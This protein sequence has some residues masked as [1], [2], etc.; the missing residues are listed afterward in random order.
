MTLTQIVRW[1]DNTADLRRNLAQGLDMIESTRVGAEKMMQ[2][3][4]G[5]KLIESAHRMTAAIGLLEKGVSSLNPQEAASKLAFLEKAMD[6]MART[7]QPIPSHM[8][9]M[10]ESLRAAIPT[11]DKLADEANRLA[12]SFGGSDLLRNANAMVM[13]V[14]KV[15]GVSKLTRSEQDDLNRTL[16]QAISKYRALGQQAPRSMLELAEATRRVEEPTTSLTT[17]MIAIG[18]AIGTFIGRIAYDAVRRL[19]SAISDIAS[20]GVQMVGLT[21]SFERL[22]RSVG[23]TGDEML[24][25]SRTATKG[26]IADLDLMAATNKGILLGLPITT[27]SMA[28][29]ARTAVVLGKAMNQSATKSLDDL[30][31]ALGRSSPMILDNLGLSVKVG[32]ANEQYAKSL[33][34]SASALTE[35]EKKLAFYNAAMAA[36]RAKVSELGDAQLTLAEMFQQGRVFFDNFTT[37]VV[38]MVARSPRLLTA[39]SETG[40]AIR[41]AF[42]GDNEQIIA[43]IAGAIEK[44]LVFVVDAV[45]KFVELPGPARL[46][47]AGIGAITIA[48]VPAAVAVSQLAGAFAALNASGAMGILGKLAPFLTGAAAIGVGGLGVGALLAKRDMDAFLAQSNERLP[49]G[50][51]PHLNAAGEAVGKLNLGLT[52]IGVSLEAAKQGFGGLT[53]SSTEAAAALALTEDEL[54]RI[55]QAVDQ[56]TGASASQELLLLSRAI[57]QI[58]TSGLVVAESQLG[59][60]VKKIHELSM[61]GGQIPPMLLEWFAANVSLERIGARVNTSVDQVTK[62]IRE[63]VGA[64]NLVLPPHIQLLNAMN[65]APDIAK[66]A[67]AGFAALGSGAGEQ[68]A[69]LRD[70]LKGMGDINAEWTMRF[71]SGLDRAKLKAEQWREH[72]LG[73]VAHLKTTLPQQWQEAVTKINEI[74]ASMVADFETGAQQIRRVLSESFASAIGSAAS[75]TN[76][77]DAARA[78]VTS[79]LGAIPVAGSVLGPLVGGLFDIGA[80]DRAMRQSH[81]DRLLG[82]LSERMNELTRATER[83]GGVV[84][85]ALRPL[86]DGLLKS[87]KLTAEMRMQLEALGGA[88][89]LEA[90]REAAQRYGRTLDQLGPKLAQLDLSSTFDQLFTDFTMLSDAGADSTELLKAMAPA[91]NDAL[92]RARRLGLK[93]PEFMRPMLESMLKMGLLT[94]EFGKQLDTLNGFEFSDSI[95]SSLSRIAEILERIEKALSNPILPELLGHTI[96]DAPPIGMAGPREPT[97]EHTTIVEVEGQVLARATTPWLP[98]EVR[99]LRLAP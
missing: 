50:G 92:D 61:A 85:S 11:V 79:F 76:G 25:V 83:F 63:Q 8:K 36:A 58:G 6:K 96:G 29:M 32:E 78:F 93:I 26:L 81:V 23:T 77:R 4:R 82:Q 15:G 94:D 9:A 68:I 30:M 35:Q 45:R 98:D 60:L 31:T 95:E 97:M 55:Q 38:Q 59:P 71:G 42:G 46:A 17:K 80:G 69:K 24:R 2:A 47:A 18:T 37:S 1:A 54:K 56:L 19:A 86:L 66:R 28:T 22:T 21:D 89:S 53:K 64:I 33:G 87:T 12:K 90:L 44:M 88:P 70:A 20:R 10:A 49:L 65:R 84:P 91:I 34:K 52:G 27:E 41:K 75:A 74:T 67:A 72:A 43:R 39:L 99:R 13:A 73:L 7:G 62:A 16:E 40:D 51:A 48:A 3:M 57:R 5:D 14:Q